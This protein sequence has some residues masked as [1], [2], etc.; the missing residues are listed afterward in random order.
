M[1]GLLVRGLLARG[2]AGAGPLALVSC[3]NLPANGDRLRGLV[4]QALALAGPPAPAELGRGNV[5]LPGH[6]GRPDRA[7]HARRTRSTRAGARSACADLAAVAAEPYTQWVIEDDFPGGRPG[8][9]ARP[10]RCSPTTP[11]RGSG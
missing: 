11:A 9:G 6:H 10:A 7:G 8:L 1:P 3:D 4:D 5:T 2:R